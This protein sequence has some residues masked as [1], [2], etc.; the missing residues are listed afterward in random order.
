M[1]EKGRFWWSTALGAAILNDTN[2]RAGEFV[3]SMYR[4]GEFAFLAPEA[5]MIWLIETSH[6]RSNR[7]VL[8]GW[9]ETS[10]VEIYS[11]PRNT[12]QSS[13]ST[14]VQVPRDLLCDSSTRRSLAEKTSGLAIADNAVVT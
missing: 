1:L 9:H 2:P 14:G 11:Q 4:Q 13:Q 8:R 10:A 12:N 7:R 6:G 3:H 5:C